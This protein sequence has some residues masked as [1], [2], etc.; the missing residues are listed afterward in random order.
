MNIKETSLLDS[1]DKENLA[2]LAEVLFDQNLSEGIIKEIPILST[3]VA[4]TKS[5]ISIRDKLFLRKIIRFLSRLSDVPL[6][7]R[8]A[9]IEKIKNSPRDKIIL[10]ENLLL[11]IDKITDVE[12]SDLIALAIIEYIEERI[13]RN[14]LELTLNAI[15]KCALTDILLITQY[16]S[17]QNKLSDEVQDRFFSAGLCG[18]SHA[19]GGFG[20]GGS[21]YRTNN[22]TKIMIRIV[23]RID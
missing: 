21:E 8:K 3:I 9:F 2:E 12:K 7:E 5:T 20:G 6:A 10:A 18:F 13:T 4:I 14:E 19:N 23:E 17:V 11:L 15:D 1:I 16:N 22:I